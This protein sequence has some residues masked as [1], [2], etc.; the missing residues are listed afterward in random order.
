MDLG[1][2]TETL[3]AEDAEHSRPVFSGTE[4]ERRYTTEESLGQGGMGLVVRATDERLGRP[5]AMKV[6]SSMGG[7]A[8]VR[9]LQE[10]QVNSQLDHPAVLPVYDLGETDGGQPF[11]TMKYIPDHDTLSDV[12]GKLRAEDP[13][14]LRAYTFERRVAVVQQVCRALHY[15]HERGVVHRDIKPS[16]IVIGRFGEVYLLDW[17]VAK[18]A[19]KPV[20]K[21]GPSDETAT[22]EPNDPTQTAANTIVGTPAYMAPEQIMESKTDAVSDVYAMCAVLYEFLTLHYYLGKD[23]PTVENVIMAAVTR[24]PAEAETF[25]NPVYGRVP[26]AL[27]RILYRGLQKTREDRYQTARELDL[28]LQ[29]WLEGRA[30]IVCPGTCMQRILARWSYHVD[31]RPIVVPIVSLVVLVLFLRWLLT[32]LWRLGEWVLLLVQTA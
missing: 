2:E 28:A 25:K 30:P 17:G 8:R 23:L 27:S 32:G 12:I 15:A 21:V 26:R 3:D 9:F 19:K 1:P 13:E 10:A 22:V 6:L 5:V 4:Q 31:Q 11:F 24:E 18:V 20:P 14:A 29:F 7:D 16:N